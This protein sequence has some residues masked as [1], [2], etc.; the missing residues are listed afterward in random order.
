M[1]LTKAQKIEVLNNLKELIKN[2]KS[3][4]FT[5]NTGLT[6]EEI[7]NL[8]ISLREASSTFTLA[9]KTLI[10]KAFKE[11]LKVELDDSLLP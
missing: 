9:K 11:I 8:R 7:T 6:V 2:A 10:K 4:G 1:A 3:I 5:S